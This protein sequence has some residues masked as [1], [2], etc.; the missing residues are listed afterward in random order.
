[1]AA[2]GTG[3]ACKGMLG[4]VPRILVMGTLGKCSRNSGRFPFLLQEHRRTGLGMDTK[5]VPVTVKQLSR[6]PESSTRIEEPC[7]AQTP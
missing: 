4:A 7:L 6:S 3:K 1:M 5:L 2:K